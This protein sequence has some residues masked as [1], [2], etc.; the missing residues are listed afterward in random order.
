MK[1]GLILL[2]L[3]SLLVMSIV[4]AKNSAKINYI[5]PSEI[6]E[7]TSQNIITNVENKKGGVCDSNSSINYMKFTLKDLLISGYVNNFYSWEYF[8]SDDKKNIEYSTISSGISCGIDTNEEVNFSVTA[9]LVSSDENYDIELLAKDLVGDSKD[10]QIKFKVLNDDLV[11]RLLSVSPV[12]FSIAPN[13]LINLNLQFQED[14]SGFVKSS[15]FIEYKDS[16]KVT[17]SGDTSRLVDL[18]C[19]D[20]LSCSG[21]LDLSNTLLS[22]FI[23]YRLK[24]ASDVAGNVLDDGTNFP[25]HIFIDNS[26]P[27]LSLS[28]PVDDFKTNK[29]ILSID[30]IASDDSFAAPSDFSPSLSCDTYLDSDIYSTDSNVLNNS[31][32][33]SNI[34]LSSIVDGVH[35]W[36]VIC[37]D[38]AGY[39]TSSESRSF[40]VD[41]QGPGITFLLEDNMTL[42]NNTFVPFIVTDSLNDV[43]HVWYSYN[44]SSGDFDLEQ[45]FGIYLIPTNLSDG[46]YLLKAYANDSFNNIN[47]SSINIIIDTISPVIDS[48]TANG[49]VSNSSV[50]LS[51]A[52]SDNH[53]SSLGCDFRIDNEF[54]DSSIIDSGSSKD[55][56]KTLS[57]GLH[58]YNVKCLDE[59]GNIIVSD[60]NYINVDDTMP[61]INLLSPLDYSITNSSDYNIIFSASDAYD[62]KYCKLYVDGLSVMENSTITTGN[63]TFSR[64]W[65][66]GNSSWSIGCVDN[67]YNSAVSES[68]ILTVDT[69]PPVISLLSPDVVEFQKDNISISFSASDINKESQLY[70]LF[71]S[72]DEFIAFSIVDGNAL[73]DKMVL[74][75]GNYV[76]HM[77]SLDRAGNSVEVFKNMSVVDNT[78]PQI[79]SFSPSKGFKFGS[80]TQNVD[81]KVNTDEES[82]CRLS[83]SS[84][85]WNDMSEM[86]NSTPFNHS[87]SLS[88]S[89]DSSYNRLILCQDLYGHLDFD[90]S[91]NLSFSVDAV[92]PGSPGESTGRGGTRR[93]EINN[94]IVVQQ[95]T[96][97]NTNV[98]R[99]IEPVTEKPSVV[100][101]SQN[102][103]SSVS[104]ESEPVNNKLSGITGTVIKAL[105]NKRAVYIPV[106]L[107]ALGILSYSGFLGV[108]HYLRIRKFNKMF[109][110]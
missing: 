88:V 44:S 46:S 29:N 69:L 5:S 108:R 109:K 12:N 82:Y 85:V 101:E 95:Q 70:E 19:N 2:V 35:S 33:P 66:E 92:A 3:I 45:L 55:I 84:L 98:I 75:R 104:V 34:D 72:N 94:T 27:S 24:N 21:L 79:L 60:T 62:I 76:L 37:S 22:S 91:L 9:P 7:G 99:N 40:S 53:A 52:A 8:I 83:Q 43:S 49:S 10:S 61:V 97:V 59:V 57:D 13:K 36:N 103:S 51:Y 86:S 25:Y 38:K 39:S 31:D 106:F 17:Y 18:E 48:L 28:S 87:F 100:E 107:G 32:N 23:D 110:L 77:T 20:S 16:D 6:Y 42:S 89:S 102:P 80:G 4:E 58:S 14:E 93:Q 30:F 26:N 73:Y 74:P 54:V 78:I 67:N 47:S 65:N 71:D 90:E 50:L 1:K 64:N 96:P 56:R 11:P 63:T 41:R 105:A 68:R 81:I 15:P